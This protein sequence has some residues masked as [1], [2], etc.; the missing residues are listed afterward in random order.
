MLNL[1][2]YT[3]LNYQTYKKKYIFVYTRTYAL[4]YLH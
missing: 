1:E 3:E 2:L 4:S